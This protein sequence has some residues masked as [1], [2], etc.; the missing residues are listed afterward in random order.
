VQQRGGH[1]AVLAYDEVRTQAD[2]KASVLDFYESAYQAG[3]AW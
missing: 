2:P 3:L 1:L